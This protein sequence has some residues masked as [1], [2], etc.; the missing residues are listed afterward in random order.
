M[1]KGHQREMK[2]LTMKNT[3]QHSFGLLGGRTG[4]QSS[5]EELK[6]GG[7]KNKYK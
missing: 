6:F 3:V 1:L 5:N 7:L 4:A 2:S